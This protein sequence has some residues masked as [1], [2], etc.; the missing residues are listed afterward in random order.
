MLNREHRKQFHELQKIAHEI[1]IEGIPLDEQ[2]QIVIIIEKPPL[3]WK[4]FKNLLLHKTKDRSIKSLI[5]H[6]RIEKD[7]RRQDQKNEVLVICNK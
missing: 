6:L 7:S 3:G 4:G 1:I 2:L 5:T